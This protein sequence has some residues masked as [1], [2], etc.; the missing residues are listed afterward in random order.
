MPRNANLPK[1]YQTRLKMGHACLK[2][3]H[4]CLKSRPTIP[5]HT[6]PYMARARAGPYSVLKGDDC[7]LT[8]SPDD[9]DRLDDALAPAGKRRKRGDSFF[10]L[11]DNIMIKC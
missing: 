3:G 10:E 11:N 9:E 6:I 4:T 5:Y 8:E 7:E 2:S 1:I